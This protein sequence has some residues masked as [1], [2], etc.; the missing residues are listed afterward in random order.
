MRQIEE[1]TE[2]AIGLGFES[3]QEFLQLFGFERFVQP[4]R[5]EDGLFEW[6]RDRLSP[7]VVQTPI[8]TCHISLY[9]Q[10]VQTDVAARYISRS[11]LITPFT[12]TSFV[13]PIFKALNAST[14]RPNSTSDDPPSSTAFAAATFNSLAFLLLSSAT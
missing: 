7:D 5:R 2:A 12:A 6:L 3:R 10:C 1:A 8:R 14:I 13:P 9:T 11:A 4:M